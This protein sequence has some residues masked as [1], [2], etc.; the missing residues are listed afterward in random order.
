VVKTQRCGHLGLPRRS[1]KGISSHHKS[2]YVVDTRACHARIANT[3]VEACRPSLGCSV[4][5][6]HVRTHQRANR[7][8]VTLLLDVSDG[9]LTRLRR[10]HAE[11]HVLRTGISCTPCVRWYVCA[12]GFVCACVFDGFL[13]RVFDGL[14]VRVCS[15]VCL[16]VCVRWY[17]CACGFVCACVFDGLLVRVCSMVC[18]CVCVRWYVCACGFVCACVFDGLLVH[19]CSMICLC[20]CVRWFVCACVFNGLLVRVCSMVCLCV[21]VRWYVCACGFV[22]AT[23]DE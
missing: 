12:C 6:I 5:S 23:P 10:C 16:C 15:M 9:V 17:V 13:V 21:C 1:G 7:F 14:L 8:R 4:L 2:S 18:L 20:V 11:G 3:V 22:C 19:V